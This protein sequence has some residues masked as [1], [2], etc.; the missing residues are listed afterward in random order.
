MISVATVRTIALAL[1]SSFV[2]AAAILRAVLS[3]LLAGG[4][5]GVGAGNLEALALAPA[6]LASLAAVFGRHSGP[7]VVQIAGQTP[8]NL[9]VARV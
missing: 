2:A 4:V 7:K 3:F 9:P 8:S 6:L 1:P 5:A